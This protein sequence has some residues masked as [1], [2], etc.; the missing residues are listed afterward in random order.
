MQQVYALV[1]VLDHWS[2][3]SL[4]W[5]LLGLLLN[6]CQSKDPIRFCR[7]LETKSYLPKALVKKLISYTSFSISLYRLIITGI[8]KTFLK[9]CRFFEIFC[10]FQHNITLFAWIDSL[11]QFFLRPEWPSPRYRLKTVPKEP[12]P[13][14]ASYS[15]VTLSHASDMSLAL[16]EKI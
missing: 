8:L 3:D 15:F 10:R 14:I 11:I 4:D 7:V 9:H 5:D 13:S 12:L 6:W 2:I 16:N 1:F